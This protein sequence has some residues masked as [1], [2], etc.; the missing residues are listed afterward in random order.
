MN[1]F[2]TKEEQDYYIDEI[3][4]MLTGAR[5]S[6]ESVLESIKAGAADIDDLGGY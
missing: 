6:K 4:F 5:H 3:N 2:L 1:N